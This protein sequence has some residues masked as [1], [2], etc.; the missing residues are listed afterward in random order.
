MDL[1]ETYFFPNFK[2]IVKPNTVSK[3]FSKTPNA[4]QTLA[5]SITFYLEYLFQFPQGKS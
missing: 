3:G 4:I 1:N 5:E 2:R